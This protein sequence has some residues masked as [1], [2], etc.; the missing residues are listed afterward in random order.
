MLACAISAPD[1]V[2]EPPSP[3]TP[4]VVPYPEDAPSHDAPIEVAARLRIDEQGGV[5]KIELLSEAPEAFGRAL[6][7][8][9][10]GFR[11]EPARYDGK[12]IAVDIKFTAIFDVPARPPPPASASAEGDAAPPV[13]ATARLEGRLRE[14]GSR[15]PVR[16]ATVV[17][18]VDG[19][20]VSVDSDDHGRFALDLPHGYAEVQVVS[21][22]HLRFL[23]RESL[24]E[25]DR[26]QV[27]YLLDRRRQD[28]YSTVVIGRRKRTEVARTELRG[29][30]LTQIPGTFGDPFRV[31]QTLPGVGAVIS[32]LPFPIVRGSSPGSTGFLIDGVRVPLLFHLLGGPSVIHPDFIDSIQFYPGGFPV[33]YGGYTA[34]IVDGIT[35]PAGEDERRIEV[36]LN[37]LQAGGLVRTP[38]EWIDGRVTLAGRI[39]WPGVLISLVN[40]EFSLSYWDYQAR[41][42]RGNK[43]DGFT[44]FAFGAQDLV[45]NAR[46][47]EAEFG[48]VTVA[49]YDPLQGGEFVTWEQ[50][51]NAALAGRTPPLQ[52]SLR[53]GFHRIDFRHH[54]R[55]GDVGGRHQ[56]AFG[57][58]DTL[59]ADDG[60]GVV[61]WS[62]APRTEWSFQLQDALELRVGADGALRTTDFSAGTGADQPADSGRNGPGDGGPGGRGGNDDGGPGGDGDGGDEFVEAVDR[63]GVGGVFAETLWR[64]TGRLLVRPGVRFEVYRDSSST[65]PAFDP[66][67]SARYRLSGADRIDSDARDEDELWVKG[68]VGLYHQ[69]P[70]FVIP[71]PGLDQLPLKNGLLAAVHNIAGVEVPLGD[72]TTL[73]AQVFFNWMDPVIFDLE[74]NEA[75]EE[76]VNSGPEV[77]PGELPDDEVVIEEDNGPGLDELL[78]PQRGRAYGLEVL[79][80]RRSRH[81]FYGWLSYTLSRSERFKEGQWRAFDF[82]RTHIFNAVLAVP[83]PRNWEIG[84]RLQY[85]TGR[86]IT[87]TFGY[88]TG[89]VDPFVRF[90]LRIDKRAVWNNWMLDF[91]VDITNVT[92]APEEVDSGDAARYVLPTVGFRGVI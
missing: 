51:Y 29:R 8:A 79:L 6:R 44:V 89:R 67:L 88:N 86:P 32:L 92:L 45:E 53:L 17:A 9:A 28:P 59:F 3:L 87:T 83:L 68:S 23:Q 57:R 37:L 71:L 62:V 81:G 65:E 64:P 54:H 63:Y 24:A 40:P 31:I 5:S 30:E 19:V 16:F 13:E 73:D 38:V 74:V 15:R 25:G 49:H 61:A 12:V 58:D 52:P 80:R 4:T 18:T 50:R 91:Y 11:F 72:R 22:P 76:R 75:V 42:D 56:V 60:A 27:G 7:E 26:L 48:Q 14:R 69:P 77:S 2:L 85:Q 1:A 41:Y 10:T 84:G 66:R 90:D 36:N 55:R 43:A 21:A 33:G 70:R 39:G 78:A 47:D 34:G 35:R 46:F 20:S 82:D